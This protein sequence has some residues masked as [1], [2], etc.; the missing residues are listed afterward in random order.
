MWQYYLPVYFILHGFWLQTLCFLEIL[1]PGQEIYCGKHLCSG[2]TAKPSD[3]HL[4]KNVS[5][6]Q[7]S[8]CF[9]TTVERFWSAS[10]E[11]FDYWVRKQ[12]PFLEFGPWIQPP[13]V[14][15][16][17]ENWNFTARSTISSTI[18]SAE[19]KKKCQ[20]CEDWRICKRSNTLEF[21]DFIKGM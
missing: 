9:S 12:P 1:I 19:V 13:P 8:R 15:V 14:S 20:W 10:K 17:S 2:F 4:L 11:P 5:L 21:E 16:S 18:V 6:P 3:V 7:T